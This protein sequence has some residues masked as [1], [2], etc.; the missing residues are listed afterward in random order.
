MLLEEGHPTKR[1]T[2]GKYTVF[3]LLT[4]NILND[5]DIHIIGLEWIDKLK[6][7]VTRIKITY[8]PFLRM[9]IYKDWQQYI[10]SGNFSLYH[11]IK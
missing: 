2:F 5:I 1:Y 8:N 3:D 6:A 9:S 7:I 11:T 4:L 10:Y